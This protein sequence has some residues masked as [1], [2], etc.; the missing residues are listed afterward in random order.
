MS[1]PNFTPF[2]GTEVRNVEIDNARV[3]VLPFCYEN[4]PSYGTGSRMGPFHILDASVQ[5]ESLD[6][7]SMFEWGRLPIHTAEPFFPSNEPEQAVLQ[8]K[9]KAEQ[10]I[11]RKQFLLSLGGDHAISLGPIMAAADAFPDIGVVQIDAHLDLRNEWNGSRFNH[12]CVM[13]RVMDDLKI[14]VVQIGI[15]SFSV[16]ESEYIKKKKL[17][18]FY[19]H[20]IE[21]SDNSWHSEALSLLPEHVYITIDIDGLDPSVVPGT[22]TPEPGG[23]SYRQLVHLIK[24]IGTNRAVIAADVTELA[25]IESSRVSEFTAAKIVTKIFV[26]CL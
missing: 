11:K 4:A 14:P 18:P 23:L 9:K 7:E 1:N 5:L 10:V 6:E 26:Y 16:E 22:G 24:T 2:G 8:M 12:A 21:P 19:A 17:T 3:V 13:R 15:R 25:K 20:E